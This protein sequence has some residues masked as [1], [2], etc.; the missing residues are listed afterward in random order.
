MNGKTFIDIN[1]N[2][3]W[4][5]NALSGISSFLWLFEWGLYLFI[6]VTLA[7]ML[8]VFFDSSNKHKEQQ[9]LVPRILSLVGV[10]AILPTFIFRFTGNAN[11]VTH[12]VR[13]MAEPGAPFYPG[14]IAY[15]VRWLVLGFGPVVAFMALFGIAMSIVSMVIY[16]STLHRSRP[17]TEFV[18]AFNGRI[19]S[20]EN[21]MSESR[22]VSGE[23]GP[24]R[25]AVSIADGRQVGGSVRSYG[26]A[27]VVDRAPQAATII[28]D[29]RTD[30]SI[31][32]CSG[33]D[34]GR[35]FNLPARDVTVGRNASCGVVVDDGKVSRVHLKLLYNAGVWSALDAGSANG[36]FVNG[37]RLLG[38]QPLFDG[39]QITLG[40]TSIAFSCR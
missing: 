32:I 15:N 10:F 13:L 40:D 24:A 26:A 9:A 18:Q 31:S 16:A 7:I 8:W 37:S 33:S 39:D 21:Q 35:V 22:H 14:P 25:G 2:S 28:D 38:K 30:A 19:A 12:F 34:R 23:A 29:P 27:T 36:T 4:L 3:Q 5:N 17:S 20:L 6:L 11:G 1:Y